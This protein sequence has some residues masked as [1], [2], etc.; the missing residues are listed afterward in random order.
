MSVNSIC[1]LYSVL[2]TDIAL[3]HISLESLTNNY[4]LNE[5]YI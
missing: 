5:Y 1:A 4:L 2:E 3:E